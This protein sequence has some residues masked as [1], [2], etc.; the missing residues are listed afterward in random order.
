MSELPPGFVLDA[1][2][3][4]LPLGFVLDSAIVPMDVAKSAGIGVVKGGVGLAGLGGDA[5]SLIGA[6]VDKA[7]SFL[8][9]APDKVQQFKELM[10]AGLRTNPAT[11]IPA[12]L[13]QGPSSQG[14]QS[15]IEDV[16]GPFY[17]PKT[18]PGEYAQTAGEF[19]PG[20]IGGPETLGTKLLTR[21]AAPAAASETAG[22]LTKG[23]A[24][25]P[26]ARVGGALL[27]GAGASKLMQPSAASTIPSAEDLL[28]S[29]SNKFE[30]VKASDAVINPS[31]V[32]QMAKDIKT[33]MLNAGKHPT[34]EGQAGVFAALDRLETMGTSSG[35]V[36]P[37][38][39]EIIRKNL[40]DLKPNLAAGPT[41]RMAADKFMEKYAGLGQ[42]DLLHGSNP[43]PTLKEA[44]GDWAAGKRSNTL[45]GKVD[46]AKL[47][48]DTAGSG[49]NADNALRQ[50]VKQLARPMNNTNTP[51]A[52]RLG[53]NDQEIAG[54][55]Q[56][57]TGTVTG[58]VSRYI[59]KAAPTGIVSGVMSGG[60]GHLAGG[61]FGAV[62]LPAA[63]YVAKKIGDLSTKRAVAAVD[64]LVRSRSPLAAQV[65]AQLSPQITQQLS[66][67]TQALLTALI[68]ADPI[69]SKQ[70]GQPV[71]QPSPY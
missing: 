69:L 22:Q 31:S 70:A 33:E 58:N 49:A 52:K 13:M 27:G 67:K 54:I 20:L 65:A 7:G 41:A 56:A 30:A 44:I 6:G 57:A 1:P 23:T 62:A 26:Y 9:A 19:L 34:S 32:E 45:M 47:N 10:K 38:D 5:G 12:N 61:P 60:A 48:A 8:G 55:K 68:A 63:G 40:V 18:V 21:V 16:T 42:G 71:G 37:K 15:K 36:T 50:A 39:M 29:G 35:G 51:V 4:G 53:F 59:G 14:I 28:K 43:F 17:K 11:S 46:L 2:D 24:A 64:S 66:P 25:E 3:I